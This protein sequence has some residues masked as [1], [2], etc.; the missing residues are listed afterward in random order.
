M[1]TAR[2]A[3]STF[4]K[5]QQQREWN[6]QGG[7]KFE[8][9]DISSPAKA[10]VF[11]PK[12]L[13]L[14][15]LAPFPWMLGSVRQIMALPE[16]LL[17]YW[18]LPSIFVGIRYLLKHEFRRS[19]LAALITAGLTFGYALGEGNAGTAYRHRAQILC[20]FLAFAAVGV[21]VR[22]STGTLDES[23]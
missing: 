21:E 8:R 14:F 9:V 3:S 5:L 17:F 4:R 12:G 10:L 16:M 19:L 1:P 20:F 15:L 2:C 18:L 7:S 13:A 6:A 11:L 23:S 22:R